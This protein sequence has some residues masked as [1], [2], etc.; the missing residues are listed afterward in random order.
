M[1]IQYREIHGFPKYRVGN[2]GSV[3]SSFRGPWRRLSFSQTPTGYR[4]VQLGFRNHRYVHRLVLEAFVGPCPDGLECRH[5]DGN[6]ANNR[7][8]NLCW[9][10]RRENCDDKMKHRVMPSGEKHWNNVLTRPIVRAIRKDRRRGKGLYDLARELGISYR[11]VRRVKER[12][13][14]ADSGSPR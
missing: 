5:L 4:Q 8:S 10:T 12:N 13:S 14:W 2:D 9:G 11:S 7:A 6:K 3:W 1:S